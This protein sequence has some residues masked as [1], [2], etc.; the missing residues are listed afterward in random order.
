MRFRLKNNE[1]HFFLSDREVE[2][3]QC[4]LKKENTIGGIEEFKLQEGKHTVKVN[5]I[6]VDINVQIVEENVGYR[7]I[8]SS[9]KHEFSFHKIKEISKYD[10]FRN[11]VAN[12]RFMV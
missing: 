4:D 12:L 3:Y 2:K 10:L 9:D 11:L 5:D 6:E 1:I 8:V 7:A